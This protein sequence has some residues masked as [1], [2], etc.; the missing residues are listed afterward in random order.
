MALVSLR[1]VS[2]AYGGRELF[3]GLSLSVLEG[4]RI[5]LVGAN[6]AGKTT[7]LRILAGAEEADGGERIA[8]RDL[9]IA[10]LP[11]EPALDDDATVLDAVRGGAAVHEAEAMVSRV[12]L[13]NP[14]ARCGTLSGG[15]RR[16]VAL[17]AV[18]LRDPGL[19]LLDEPTNHLD[20][21][22]TQW[23]EDLLLSIRV[24]LVMVTHDR[25]FLDR[26]ASRIVELDRGALYLSEGG[27]DAFL[28]RRIARL[29]AER[30]A[31]SSRLNVLRREREWIRRGPKAQR[32]KDKARIKRFEELSAGGTAAVPED[33]ELHI[34]PGP[35]L[36]TKVFRLHGVTREP[37]FKDVDLEIGRGE[38]VGIVGPNGAGKTTLLKI[39][40][41]LLAPDRGRVET[42]ETVAAAYVDQ[43]REDLD[44][45]KSVLREIAGEHGTVEIGGRT[46]RV[47]TLLGRFLFDTAQFQT[48]VKKLSGGELNR[49]LLAKLLAFG[50]QL[51]ERFTVRSFEGG[52][53]GALAFELFPSGG[54]LVQDGNVLVL[55]EPTNDLDLPTLRAL[56]EALVAFRGTVLVVT[57]D[58]WF[59][60]R[61]ATRVLYL[62]GGGGV[63]EWPGDMTGLLE[64]LKEERAPRERKEKTER[65]KAEPRKLGYREQRELEGLPDRIAERE[66]EVARLDRQLADPA[67]Y[68]RPDV[69]E[70]VEKRAAAAAE[71]E[72]LYA[73]WEE[74][75]R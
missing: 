59:L 57:H 6:G 12:G 19:L 75:E 64:R 63:R 50:L 10:Y 53:G 18:L 56:E 11:Q 36:G 26:V 54:P 25:Y 42:G 41:G 60:D 32:T 17:A 35:H 73:R 55:D 7:L 33:L 74:L 30:R 62:D 23:L 29:A 22:V 21:F 27:Y 13:A 61:V 37:L 45:E 4:D 9:R 39:I 44:P 70:I 15:E 68:T 67:T 3:A 69:A 47:E 71:L 72:R 40:L 46:V 24:P 28:E 20:A 58:R 8:P 65:P 2:K 31:E 16:R 14:G 1:G 48:P 5:G 52:R 51:V 49:V 43:T 34:P 66:D 38:R